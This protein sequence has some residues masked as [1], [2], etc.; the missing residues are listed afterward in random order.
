MLFDQEVLLRVAKGS[1]ED[2]LRAC[3]GCKTTLPTKLM[4]RF[5]CNPQGELDFDVRAVLQ[6]RGAW[7]CPQL[8]CVQ[9]SL[10]RQ[11][12]ARCLRARPRAVDAWDLSERVCVLLKEQVLTTMGLAYRAGQCCFGQQR[13]LQ[14][15]QQGH[16]QAFVYACD[17][18]DRARQFLLDSWGEQRDTIFD[19]PLTKVQIGHCLGQQQVGCVAIL[20]GALAASLRLHLQRLCRLQSSLD[21]T[22]EEK[23]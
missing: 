23:K 21:K 4:L 10:Q 14:A 18:A 8:I 6:G 22:C 16:A 11:A 19:P 5:V 7:V 12:F 13:C 15:V 9:Q 17:L 3:A 20:S 1:L 2:C